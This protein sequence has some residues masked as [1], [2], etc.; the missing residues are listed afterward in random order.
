MNIKDSPYCNCL[1]FS[2]GAMSRQIQKIAEE[3]FRETGLS[4]SHA[5]VLM[6]VNARQEI[7]PGEIAK[8]LFLAPST[9]TRLI[10]KLEALQLVQRENEGKYMKVITTSKG[11]EKDIRIRKAWENLFKRYTHTL[12][13]SFSTKL[14]ENLQ[15]A[16]SKSNRNKS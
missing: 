4:P 14:T 16:F 1:Y 3:E 10:E 6:S 2:L 8:E 9:V 15:E 5:F 12:G 13:Q 7:N 11:L